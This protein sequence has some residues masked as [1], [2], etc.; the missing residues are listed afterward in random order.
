MSFPKRYPSAPEDRRCPF[1]RQ[2]GT[3]LGDMADADL[4]SLRE[5]MAERN[6]E[7]GFDSLMADV[8]AVLE[9]RHP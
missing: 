3:R 7:G 6:Q 5:W 4:W 2:K 9:G 1:G 8:E